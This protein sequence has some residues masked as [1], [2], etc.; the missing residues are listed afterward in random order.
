VIAWL[1]AARLFRQL[2]MEER[3]ARAVDRASR[4]LPRDAT[5]VGRELMDAPEVHP[6]AEHS[7]RILAQSLGD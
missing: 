3:M 5:L 4:L 6:S 2:G 7:N 1:E